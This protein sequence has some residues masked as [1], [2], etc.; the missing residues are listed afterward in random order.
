MPRRRSSAQPVGLHAGERPHQRRLAVVDVP[1]GGDDVHATSRRR[2]TQ[3]GLASGSSCSARDAAQVEQAAAVL[4]PAD[5][6]A[7]RRCAAAPRSRAGRA[8]RPRRQLDVRARRRRPRPTPR[9]TH[10]GVDARQRRRERVRPRPQ[11]GRVG[12]AGACRTG[13]RRP[14]QRGLQRGQGE[15]VD[16]QRAGQ[17]VP[18]Q[19]LDHARRRRAAAR[20]AGRRAACRRWP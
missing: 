20:P 18:A 6:P 3:D 9:V 11:L 1:G 17:R 12:V 15:L 13:G 16:P 2:G 19:P 8:E 4:D 10:L 14:A 5:A 7:G